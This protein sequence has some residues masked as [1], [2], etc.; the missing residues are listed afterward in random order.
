MR[1]LSSIITKT[2]IVIVAVMLIQLVSALPSQAAPPANG[3]GRY[4]TV[5][6]GETLSSI[7]RYYGV[8]PYQISQANGLRNAN[9][10][11]SGQRLYIPAKTNYY[12]QTSYRHYQKYSPNYN[13]YGYGQT[14]GYRNNHRP[15]SGYWST[16]PQQYYRKGN[17]NHYSG[18]CYRHNCY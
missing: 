3:G 10:I 7:G 17:T 12:P 5:R 4:H 13:Y 16:Y 14:Y 2:L 11:Y 9:Y 6:Y 15:Y 8:N 1:S 18:G